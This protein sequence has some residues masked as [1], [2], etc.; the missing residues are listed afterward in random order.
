MTDADLPVLEKFEELWPKWLELK[1]PI[2]AEYRGLVAGPQ[3]IKKQRIADVEREYAEKLRQAKADLYQAQ[4]RFKET[5]YT[6]ARWRDAS[7]AAAEQEYRNAQQPASARRRAKLE[8]LNVW[9]NRERE[10]FV[11]GEK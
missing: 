9:F 1:E 11:Q 10:R 6:L 2:E 3:R 8:P 4:R 5:R 7:I